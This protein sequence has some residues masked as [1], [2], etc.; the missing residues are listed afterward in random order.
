ME[1]DKTTTLKKRTPQK[2]PKPQYSRKLRERSNRKLTQWGKIK[3]NFFQ[4]DFESEDELWGSSKKRKRRTGSSKSIAKRRRVNVSSMTQK[5]ILLL[6]K[7]ENRYKIEKG[8][9]MVEGEIENE[10]KKYSHILKFLRVFF[11]GNLVDENLDNYGSDLQG[12]FVNIQWKLG[13]Q[14]EGVEF[15]EFAKIEIS[16]KLMKS[17]IIFI[18]SHKAI[19]SKIDKFM[20]K[21]GF[22]YIE[23]ICICELNLETSEDFSGEGKAKELNGYLKNLDSPFFKN[24]KRSLLMYRRVRFGQ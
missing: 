2:K 14:K 15:D 18:W 3:Q 4:S 10:P 23:N 1:E 19:L 22:R 9:E 5:E 24:S 13:E 7:K 20:E 21:L 8:E 12:I 6:W 11:T 16:K 17:G